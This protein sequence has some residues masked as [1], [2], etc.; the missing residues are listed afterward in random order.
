MARIICHGHLVTL[1]TNQKKKK[2]KDYIYIYIYTGLHGC[3]RLG[4]KGGVG[5]S[6]GDPGH[7]VLRAVGQMGRH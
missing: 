2:K 5:V 1:Q 6:I 7:L 4:N 3:H